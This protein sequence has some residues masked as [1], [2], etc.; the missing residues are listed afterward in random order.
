[1]KFE[2]MLKVV[3][4]R[5]PVAPPGT[6]IANENTKVYIIGDFPRCNRKARP[7]GRRIIEA[8]SCVPHLPERKARAAK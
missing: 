2:L 5:R 1:M 3:T 7:R 8:L 4:T 6:K